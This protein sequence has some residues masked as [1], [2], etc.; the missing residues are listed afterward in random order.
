MNKLITL[1]LVLAS[2]TALSQA[3]LKSQVPY[4][5]G[6]H[7]TL[8]DP[9]FDT[10]SQ[11]QVI[12]YEFFGYKCP[13]CSSFQLYAEPWAKKLPKNVK[14]VRVPVVFQPGWDI[15]AKAYY[16]AE[17]MGIIEKTHQ[18][19]FN[20]IHKEHKRF[21]TIEDVADWYAQNFN[22]DKDAFLSTANS[23]MIDS[24]IRQSDNMM[25]K[26]KITSTPSIIIN[27]KYKPNKKT[28]ASNAALLEL[29]TY[30]SNKEVKTMGL[31][32]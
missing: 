3:E 1:I 29:A 10:E 19:M 28:L 12:V 11:D 22:V 14:L 21:R 18:P 2:F 7:Y 16:T 24:K 15:L 4:E 23:F 9:V 13:H 25:R 17:T 27:G 20:A 6:L 30:L 32:E 5:E 26:M 8:L 31:T